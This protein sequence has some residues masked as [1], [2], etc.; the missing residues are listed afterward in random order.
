MMSFEVE[1][2]GA[3]VRRFRI[4]VPSEEL[5]RAYQ[6]HL[7]RLSREVKLP[8]FRPGKVPPHVLEKRFGESVRTEVR[9]ES[10]SKAY[11]EALRENHLQPLESP[12]L[13]PEQLQP[14]DDGSLQVEFEIEVRPEFELQPYKSLKASAPPVNVTDEEVDAAIDRLRKSLA[15]IS[16]VGSG[17]AT[18]QDLL[19]ADLTY[20]F[21]DGAI[22]KHEGRVVDLTSGLLDQTKVEHLGSMFSGKMVGDVARVSATLP[23]HFQPKEQAGR[24]P[25]IDVAIRK[26]HRVAMPGDDD[27]LK[28]VGAES[29]DQLRSLMRTRL[30]N[31][32]TEERDRFLEEQCVD[33][34]VQRHEFDLPPKLLGRIQQEQAE[35]LRRQMRGAGAP[36]V[37]V[38]RR[39]HEFEGRNAELAQ[40]RLKS[41]F[42]LDR[43]AEVEKTDVS[44]KDLEQALTHIAEMAGEDAPRI[45]EHYKDRDHLAALALDVR[46]MKVRSLLRM[47]AEVVE[48]EGGASGQQQREAAAG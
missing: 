44:Q 27:F 22:I 15:E 20:T 43:I 40:K 25:V 10:L 3:C 11:E 29:M 26:I 46:R 41:R 28:R 23:E 6:Q 8:G 45:M 33:L 38:E 47:S 12:P 16:D 19:L 5:S 1:T 42:I 34:L 18:S 2:I 9:E 37:E 24:T 39:V 21:L 13:K 32:K 17:P 36:D 30:T 14:T 4:R 35:S 31:N 7:R 48:L